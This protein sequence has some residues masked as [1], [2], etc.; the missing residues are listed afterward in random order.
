VIRLRLLGPPELTIDGE[1][2]P[3]EVLWRKHLALLAY[4]ATSPRRARTRDHL[5]GLLWGDRADA[6]ARHSLREAIRVLRQGLGADVIE[7]EGQL[8]RLASDALTLDT[9]VFE[10]CVAR[11]AWDE[12]VKLVGGEFLEGLGIPNASEFEDWLTAR[13]AEWR[14]RVT[15]A[16]LA[17]ANACLRTARL[18]EARRTAARALAA[19]PLSDLAV[20]TAMQAEALAGDPAASLQIHATFVRRA[21]ET[22][23]TPSVATTALAERI[24][25]RRAPPRPPAARGQEPWTR[26]APLVGRGEALGALLDAWERVHGEGAA[27]VCVVEGDLG[28]GKTR[29]LEEVTSRAVLR[30]GTVARALAVRADR[31]DPGSGLVGLGRGG[32]LDAP[33]IAAAP[34]GALAS[35]ASRMVI[36]ASRFPGAGAGDGTPLGT[37]FREVVL[38]ALEE[39][40]L[41]L[42]VDEAH[43]LDDE[44]LGALLGLMRDARKRPLLLLLTIMPSAAVPALD[45]L[46]SALAGMVAGTAVALAPL[47]EDDLRAL[48][49]WALPSYAPAALE[50]VVRRLTADS[51]GVPLLAVEL[52]HAITLG[53][54]PGEST[55]V[56]PISNRTL[57]QTLPAD[58]PDSVVAAVRVGFR[59]LSP[60]AQHVL[61]ALAVLAERAPDTLIARAL[62]APIDGTRRALDELEWQ[63]WV[64]ADAR[65]YAFLARI[66]RD[67]VDRDML[68]AGQRQRIAEAAGLPLS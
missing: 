14:G 15:A 5:V 16:L 27:A 54:E 11:N 40:P 43:W 35:M 53:L 22:G 28:L 18:D 63:R 65:G 8:V 24:R 39:Q 50:R 62:G 30:G 58:L 52:L 26:R 33:G 59:G 10:D 19:E 36:W 2:P 13:R 1:A 31:E 45:D 32:L 61:T 44:S 20:Q 48:A 25:L 57:D 9:E 46:R 67:V 49:A 12:A 37:A 60:A 17:H 34:Q 51:A 3:A 38:A 56:W 66:V 7:A 68:T 23:V 47:G 64:T 42:A 55:Q 29:V 21:Q 41:V 4:L 6:A